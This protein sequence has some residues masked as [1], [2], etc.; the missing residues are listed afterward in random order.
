MH[1]LYINKICSELR[2]EI[3]LTELAP[4]P[5]YSDTN[6]HLVDM[7]VFAKF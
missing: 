5:F 4:I 1:Y 6:V 7:N 2:R 3:T